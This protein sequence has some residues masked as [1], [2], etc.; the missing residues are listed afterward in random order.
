MTTILRLVFL[1]P[2]S[3]FFLPTDSFMILSESKHLHVTF[4]W[5]PEKSEDVK[6]LLLVYRSSVSSFCYSLLYITLNNYYFALFCLVLL[7]LYFQTFPT[8]QFT[9]FARGF[10]KLKWLDKSSRLQ[11]LK[12]KCLENQNQPSNLWRN[13][14]PIQWWHSGHSYFKFSNLCVSNKNQL[15]FW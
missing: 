13:V 6:K 5:Q 1:S 12:L 11:N 7:H 3:L 8:L 9:S 2:F 10:N 15:K 4:I 14:L